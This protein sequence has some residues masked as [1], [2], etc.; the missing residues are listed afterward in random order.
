[1]NLFIVAGLEK[2]YLHWTHINGTW[3]KADGL[4]ELNNFNIQHSRLLKL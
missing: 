1:M 4:Y 2:S 3:L